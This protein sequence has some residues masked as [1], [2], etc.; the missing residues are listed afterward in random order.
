[1]GISLLQEIGYLQG[2]LSRDLVK[3]AFEVLKPHERRH[4]DQRFLDEIEEEF[5]AALATTIGGWDWVCVHQPAIV[6]FNPKTGERT[7]PRVEG[8][9]LVDILA[10][11]VVAEL[12]NDATKALPKFVGKPVDSKKMADEVGLKAVLSLGRWECKYH[13]GGCYLYDARKNEWHGP[14]T[15]CD[16]LQTG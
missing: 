7:R 15:G 5:K 10:D 4:V 2:T 11:G 16:E 9:R 3:A 6:W 13:Y 1:M 8:K 14:C 12:L